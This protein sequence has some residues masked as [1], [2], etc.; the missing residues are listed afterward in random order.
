MSRRLREDSFIGDQTGDAY[1]L[2]H[3][4][5][6]IFSHVAA[7]ISSTYSAS[8]NLL[9]QSMQRKLTERQPKSS[10]TGPPHSL[11]FKTVSFIL[12][13]LYLIRTFFLNINPKPK[14][15]NKTTDHRDILNF[16]TPFNFKQFPVSSYWK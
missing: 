6:E 8:P 16:E 14:N 3:D 11:H 2:S 9:L 5:F 7:S 13:I 10:F 1:A 4:L 12:T 15:A